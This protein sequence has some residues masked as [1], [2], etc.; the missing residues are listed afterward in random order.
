[1]GKCQEGLW[2]VVQNGNEVDA[3]ATKELR[4]KLKTAHKSRAKSKR[5]R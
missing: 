2:N 5:R 4:K 1:M 3:K